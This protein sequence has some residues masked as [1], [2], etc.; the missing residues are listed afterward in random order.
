MDT[1]P[2]LHEPRVLT[3][4]STSGPVGVDL[5]GASLLYGILWRVTV[6]PASVPAVDLG[7]DY[8]YLP[9]GPQLVVKSVVQDSP[10]K[11]L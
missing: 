4:A 9:A 1:P 10:A 7:Y 3:A 2:S 11:R 6:V 8:D 5:R